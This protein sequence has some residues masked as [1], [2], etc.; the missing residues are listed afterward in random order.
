MSVRRHLSKTESCG[1]K[2][3]HDIWRWNGSE[4]SYWRRWMTRGPNQWRGKFRVFVT[5]HY[6]PFLLSVEKQLSTVWINEQLHYCVLS[7]V[8]DTFEQKLFRVYSY[9]VHHLY[10]FTNKLIKASSMF[11]MMQSIFLWP[12]L[13]EI[14]NAWGSFNTSPFHPVNMEAQFIKTA[15]S[16]H[17]HTWSCI[18]FI[19]CLWV[20]TTLTYGH[21]CYWEHS[22]VKMWW[23]R[24]C[25]DC[26]QAKH[27]SK[28]RWAGRQTDGLTRWSRQRASTPVFCGTCTVVICKR[29]INCNAH[30]AHVKNSA[31]EL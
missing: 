31:L 25:R 21:S 22:A 1:S 3:S 17:M 16:Y 18:A 12:K 10:C 30:M 9:Q 4:H 27:V 28:L 11:I 15:L 5:L 29:S 23:C 24:Y 8:I 14:I 13:H 26:I 2:T 19:F 6:I 7:T 20:Y